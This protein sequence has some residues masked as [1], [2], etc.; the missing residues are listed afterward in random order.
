M[1]ANAAGSV[2]IPTITLGEAKSESA[3]LEQS[4]L[5]RD[6]CESIG[7][8]YLKVLPTSKSTSIEYGH[9]HEHEDILHLLPRVFEQSQAFFD[10]PL[11]VKQKISDPV[12]NRG[13][14][15]MEEETLD[16][17]RQNRGRG[18]TK[19]GYYIG[20]HVP[21]T[22]SRYNPAKLSGP[23][24]WPEIDIEIGGGKTKI[25]SS[26][27][28]SREWRSC[29]MAY[30]KEMKHI[31]FQLVQ[32]IAMALDLPQ[33]HFDQHFQEPMALL[34]LLHY[35]NEKSDTNE[36][37]YSCGAHSDY[38]M[39]TLLAT[40]DTPGLQIY[41]NEDLGWVDVPPPPLGTF[42]VNLGDMMER[43]TNGKVKSTMH[44]VLSSGG[45]DRYSIPFFYDPSFDTLVVPL[46]NCIGEDGV[47][48]YPPT[49]SGQ[50]ILDK[51]K[52]TH[53][54]FIEVKEH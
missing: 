43:W 44:R 3:T 36:G 35:T 39:V 28:D 22:D 8:F 7:F 19:E 52:E 46:D 40:D 18:D 1:A 6:A 16:P 2:A 31:S 12:M 13:Y 32:L 38:G 53:A 20:D 9:D 17:V 42:V 4:K 45:K 34:R 21:V 48:M 11:D 27:F 25:K 49:T 5:L 10:L 33:N 30:H 54:D 50:H 41:Y 37:I 24:I 47:A 23:N 29:M 15:G 51:Y 14:T 26:S